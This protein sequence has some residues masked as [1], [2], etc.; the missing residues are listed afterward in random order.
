MAG[1]IPPPSATSGLVVVVVGPGV[2]SLSRVDAPGIAGESGRTSSGGG[3]WE[4]EEG[5]MLRDE[6]AGTAPP[7]AELLLTMLAWSVA[8]MELKP[9]EALPWE[10]AL[11]PLEPK[12]ECFSMMSTGVRAVSESSA[13]GIK[14]MMSQY[15]SLLGASRVRE[16]YLY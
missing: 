5:G 12:C 7:A 13:Y 14:A 3:G 16:G 11:A 8:A 1:T 4:E 2:W 9:R 15:R 10:L 6:G